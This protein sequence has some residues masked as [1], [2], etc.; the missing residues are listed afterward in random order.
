MKTVNINDTRMT[1]IETPSH[2]TT[3]V[4]DRSFHRTT[5][6]QTLAQL[7]LLWTWCAYFR[8]GQ[9]SRAGGAAALCI[10]TDL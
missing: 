10:R 7:V 1:S 4:N 2:F 5:T 9:C 6:I 3:D 8:G